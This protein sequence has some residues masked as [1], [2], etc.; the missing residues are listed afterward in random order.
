MKIH[1]EYCEKWNYFPEFERVSNIIKKQYP[2]IIIEG[3]NFSPR[4]GSFEIT[5][6]KL[7]VYSK[8][9]TD[10]FPKEHEILSWLKPKD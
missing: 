7:L 8:F 3:N 5:I 9:Q 10:N 4:T 2:D 1:I 6:N